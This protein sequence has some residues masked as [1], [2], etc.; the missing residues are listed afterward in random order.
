MEQKTGPLTPVFLVFLLDGFCVVSGVFTIPL[1]G[2]SEESLVSPAAT[3]VPASAGRGELAGSMRTSQQYVGSRENRL[4]EAAVNTLFA[5]SH[6]ET[7]LST[8]DSINPMVFFGSAG[9]GK[10]LLV[11][12]VAAR[13]KVQYPTDSVIMATGVDLVRKLTE[14]IQ[15]N[16]VDE[17]AS[18]WAETS[19]LVIDDIH[20]V[21]GRRTAEDFL[22]GVLDSRYAAGLPMLFSMDRSP[23]NH[24]RLSQRLAGRL[25]TGLSVPLALPGRHA[26][27]LILIQLAARAGL[28]VDDAGCQLLLDG[29][30]STGVVFQTPRQIRQAALWMVSE[31]YL[32]VDEQAAKVVLEHF[33][34]ARRPTLKFISSLVGRRFSVTL[35]QL[36]GSSRKQG[37]VTARG[38]AMLLAKRHSGSSYV[39]IGK[40]FGGRDHSTVIHACRRA[41]QKAEQDGGFRQALDE[42]DQQL[43]ESLSVETVT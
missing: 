14:A 33:S 10:S 11:L 34:K 21:A 12:G 25:L 32:V 5:T 16:G 24:D 26:R 4:V 37:L 18:G 28:K 6:S 36:Q 35:G 29:T 19:L 17:M 13:W 31:G 2:G 1:G 39:Q 8:P 23:A 41:T 15:V 30:P 20:V 3:G 42:I 9:T 7:G 43:T 38:A 22:C 40:Y 27:Q